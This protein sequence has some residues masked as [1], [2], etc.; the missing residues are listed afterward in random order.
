MSESLHDV[1][2]WSVLNFFSTRPGKGALDVLLSATDA[3]EP[4]SDVTETALED[5]LNV[6]A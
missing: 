1:W 4:G 2:G 3:I 6:A 5:G